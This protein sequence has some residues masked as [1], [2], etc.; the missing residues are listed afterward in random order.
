MKSEALLEFADNVFN[1]IGIKITTEGKCH[2]SASLGTD[3]FLEN[4]TIDKVNNWC[5]EI[6]RLSEF[7]KSSPQAI[8]VLLFYKKNCINIYTP[9]EH[10]PYK[11]IF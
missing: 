8:Y 11:Y 2:L 7:A 1:G 9:F 3:T 6:E 4:C 10:Y 5:N